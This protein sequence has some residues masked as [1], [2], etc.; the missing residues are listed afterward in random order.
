MTC[1][2]NAALST[3]EVT[4]QSTINMKSVNNEPERKWEDMATAYFKEHLP[5]GE[6]D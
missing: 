2:L 6:I 1:L 3:A 5:K 4:L